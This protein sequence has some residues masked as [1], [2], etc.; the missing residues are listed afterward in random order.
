M[1]KVMNKLRFFHLF[2]FG[3]SGILVERERERGKCLIE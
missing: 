1:V 3:F 2:L